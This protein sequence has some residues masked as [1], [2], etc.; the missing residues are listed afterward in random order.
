MNYLIEVSALYEVEGW[1]CGD[2]ETESQKLELRVTR[3]VHTLTLKHGIPH[4]NHL[5]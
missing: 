1:L 3:H 2:E 4:H 5:Q